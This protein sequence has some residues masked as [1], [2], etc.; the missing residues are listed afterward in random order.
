MSIL[1]R[2]KNR[3]FPSG[4]VDRVSS[5][6][7]VAPD[8]GNTDLVPVFTPMLAALLLS[9][10][11]NKREP[12]TPEEVSEIR[13][14]AT[15]IMMTAAD[16]RELSAGDRGEDIDPE[17]CWH[18]WQHLRREMDR[19]PDLDPGPKFDQVRRADP[20]YQKTIED[21]RASLDQF[22][23]MLPPDGSPRFEA[24][25]KSEVID[26]EKSAFLWL[27]N[28]RFSDSGFVAEFYDIPK[29]FTDYSDGDELDISEEQVL[30]WMVND[31]GTLHGGFSIR[32]QREKTPVEERATYDEYI[33]V[34]TYA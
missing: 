30:D 26:G 32:Y 27:A 31:N 17:N 20:A 15:C 11:D 23:E 4:A 12:L 13:D 21:A 16:A 33:G 19:K 22:R 5:H 29:T 3:L 2:I 14:R 1:N 9:A 18:D 28:V 8:D 25:V 24:M 10:E 34:T 7:E 6:Q